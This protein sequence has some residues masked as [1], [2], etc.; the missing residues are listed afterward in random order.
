MNTLETSFLNR[1][2]LIA[3]RTTLGLAFAT[4]AALAAG[5]VYE[6]RVLEESGSGANWFLKGGDF[7]GS[8]YSPLST[9]NNLL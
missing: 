3:G 5:D 2:R 6:E 1:C 7:S 9:L 4:G 8:H